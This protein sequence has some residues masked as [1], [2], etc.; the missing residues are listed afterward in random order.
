MEKWAAKIKEI[1][2]KEYDFKKA[3]IAANNPYG[4]WTWYS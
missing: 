3:I 4:V 2:N 1:K